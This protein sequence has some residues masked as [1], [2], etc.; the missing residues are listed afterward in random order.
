MNRKNGVKNKRKV[1]QN[2]RSGGTRRVKIIRNT[3]V[4]AMQEAIER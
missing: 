2:P 1:S 4:G 3:K